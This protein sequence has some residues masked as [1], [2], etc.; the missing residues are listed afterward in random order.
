MKDKK[1]YY[2]VFKMSLGD[3]WRDPHMP[4]GETLCGGN[5]GGDKVRALANG[6]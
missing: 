6:A 5:G 1:I 4:L 2:K 3:Q